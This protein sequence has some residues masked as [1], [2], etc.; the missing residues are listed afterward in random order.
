[1]M[2]KT[3]KKA[4]LFDMDG[5]LFDTERIYYRKHAKQT[6][7][8]LEIEIPH[9]FFIGRYKK[10]CDGGGTHRDEKN[11]IVQNYLLNLCHDNLP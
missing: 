10:H 1:M 7:Q 4:V 6:R 8:G 9:I 11:R 3:V 2:R 5:T